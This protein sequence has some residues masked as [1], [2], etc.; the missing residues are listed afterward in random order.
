M[1]SLYYIL[2]LEPA[3]ASM[4]PYQTR[5]LPNQVCFLA[6]FN[7]FELGE[8][9]HWLSWFFTSKS[10]TL[11]YIDFSLF[12]CPDVAKRLHFLI[13]Q[14]FDE[15]RLPLLQWG[16]HYD[17]LLILHNIHFQTYRHSR[18]NNWLDNIYRVIRRQ[19]NVFHFFGLA[20]NLAI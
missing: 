9:C 7:W 3:L 6:F 4:C 13:V 14:L 11:F 8:R 19:I 5:D 16:F 10:D 17:H 2:T 15:N 1:R 18:I 12:F 20:H